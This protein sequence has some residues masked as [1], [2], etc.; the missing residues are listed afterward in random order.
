MKKQSIRNLLKPVEEDLKEIQVLFR[1]LASSEVRAVDRL[2]EPI[3]E[4]SGKMLR[5]ALLMLVTRMLLEGQDGDGAENALGRARRLA[6]VIELLHTATL[7]HDD[8]IDEADRRR[9]AASHNA[10]FGNEIS[11]LTGDWCYLTALQAAVALRSYPVLDVLLDVVRQMVEGELI[12][13]DVIGKVDLSE[14]ESLDIAKRKTACLF[15]ACTSMAGILRGAPA[16]QVETL[17]EIGEAFG[18]AFQLM[19]DVLDFTADSAELG[20]PIMN[21]LREGKA[22]LP[23]ILLLRRGD[24]AHR[25]M[26]EAVMAEKSFASVSADDFRNILRE[27]GCIDTTVTRARA[28]IQSGKMMLEA[29]P[30]SASRE[31]LL[32]LADFILARDF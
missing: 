27:A 28:Y 7:I 6:A 13:L 21:D 29:F 31:S 4:N 15:S 30:P 1:E 2:S 23:V 18:L 25:Q 5:P 10:L 19:D 9:G 14:E 8:V 17:R 3:R 20:K 12:Q 26:V 11:V 32:G 16:E 24:P 22:T